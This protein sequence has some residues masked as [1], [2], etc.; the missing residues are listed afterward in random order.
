MADLGYSVDFKNFTLC[1]TMFAT[2]TGFQVI[3]WVVYINVLDPAKHNKE[4]AEAEYQVT[5][6]VPAT[7]KKG[8]HPR[9]V[10]RGYASVPFPF[11]TFARHSNRPYMKVCLFCVETLPDV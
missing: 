6:K 10:H 3:F 2:S 7:R 5:D 1:Q 8:H 4:L 9:R 11:G